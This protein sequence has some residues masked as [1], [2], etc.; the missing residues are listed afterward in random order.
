MNAYIYI[1]IYTFIYMIH[2][3]MMDSSESQ[4]WRVL[5]PSLIQLLWNPC[6]TFKIM[7]HFTSVLICRS[8]NPYETIA[9]FQIEWFFFKL[10]CYRKEIIFIPSSFLKLRFIKFIYRLSTSWWNFSATMSMVLTCPV[11]SQP[12]VL[13]LLWYLYWVDPFSGSLVWRSLTI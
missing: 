3:H 10:L 5:K 7:L 2:I 11:F 12:L 6:Y 13:C 9:F 8:Y 1:Y 4:I